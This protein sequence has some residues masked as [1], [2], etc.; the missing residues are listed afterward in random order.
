MHQ[1][2]KILVRNLEDYV[3][4]SYKTMLSEHKTSLQRK[5]VLELFDGKEN[6]ILCHRKEVDFI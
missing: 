4:S 6:F 1:N 2:P 3:F 5:E